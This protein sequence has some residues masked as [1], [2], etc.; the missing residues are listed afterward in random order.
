MAL[1]AKPDIFGINRNWQVANGF[2]CFECF[3]AWVEAKRIPVFQVGE[4]VLYERDDWFV[5]RVWFPM[6]QHQFRY[7]LCKDG[8]V[9][10]LI[11]ESLLSKSSKWDSE[12]I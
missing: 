3:E 2:E 11:L 6:G 8:D 10:N 7:D 4:R 9:K 12:A 5:L 1:A